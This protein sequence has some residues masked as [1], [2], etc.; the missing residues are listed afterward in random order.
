[1]Y[2]DFKLIIECEQ[3]PA[4]QLS[5]ILSDLDK[6]FKAFGR[7]QEGRSFRAEITVAS[8]RFGSIEILMDA[9]GA[10]EKLTLA[11]QY[12]APFATHLAEVAKHVID[13]RDHT[14]LSQ[15]S[16]ADKKVLRSLAN[17][18]ANGH[19]HQINIVNNG[20]FNV[21]VEDPHAAQLLLQGIASRESLTKHSAVE[22]ADHIPVTNRQLSALKDGSLMGT[23][24]QVDGTWYARLAGQNGVLVP[25]SLIGLG[26]QGLING[27]AYEFRGTVLRGRRG[28]ING[29][30]IENAQAL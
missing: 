20:N 25:I 18:V 23:V 29:L 19:A 30:A 27:K 16:S 22:E 17:P 26:S 6:S 10:V 9:I 21:I 4:A 1:M 3:L 7:E 13:W 11:S 14:S 8:V 12:L 28:E 5:R 15:I 2:S 24:F